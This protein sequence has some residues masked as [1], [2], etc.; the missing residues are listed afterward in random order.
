MILKGSAMISVEPFCR[1]RIGAVLEFEAE[2]RRQEPDTFFMDAGED[3]RVRLEGS[4]DDGRFANAVSL[5]ACES[6]RVIGRIDAVILAARSDAG[7]GCAY[8]DWICV[9]KKERHRQVA[10]FL[11]KELRRELRG[12]GVETLIAIMAHNPE[13]VRFYQA[14][15]NASIHDEAVWMDL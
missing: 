4:F 7:C 6:G 5:L 3:Y 11:L 12:R 14:V 1:D 10:Q 9:L 15:E 13:A 8:L 2:L